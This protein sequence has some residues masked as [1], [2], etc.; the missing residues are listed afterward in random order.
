MSN[1]LI[2]GR[3]SSNDFFQA[4]KNNKAV[5][6]FN[7]YQSQVVIYVIKLDIKLKTKIFVFSEPDLVLLLCIA[8]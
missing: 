8:L 6:C 4:A 3:Q 2:K 1:F 5:K 7:R